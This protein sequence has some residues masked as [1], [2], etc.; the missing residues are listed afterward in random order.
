M[1]FPDEDQQLWQYFREGNAFAF[2]QLAQ[3]FYR[4][5]YQ[6]ATKF[7]RDTTLIEDSIQDVFLKLWA[8][9]SNLSETPSVKFYLFK[10]LRNH[11]IKVYHKNHSTHALFTW[12]EEA[13]EDEHAESQ[14]IHQEASQMTMQRLQS[15]VAGLPKR[16][17]E[18]LY[19]RYY[20]NLSYE[21]I[22]QIM[23]INAQ[24]V[25][26]L[27]QHSLKRLRDNWHWL[28]LVLAFM[29]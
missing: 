13:S 9:R 17:Q 15:H 2:G 3:K 20:E 14:I 1:A 29:S 23:G 27:L 19:L 10:T 21:Q 28:L 6:Y 25:A 12:Q 16:Q 5:L 4:P 24:S 18:A 22:A 11:L 7:T 8:R 26:N